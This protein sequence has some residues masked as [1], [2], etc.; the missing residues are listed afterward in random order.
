[1]TKK[2]QLLAAILLGA[3]CLVS[4]AAGNVEA[5]KQ[6]AA[7][8]M[9]CHGPDGNTVPEMFAA[10]KAPKLA[11]QLPEYLEKQLRDFK[12]GRRS[13][14]Q[15]SP[16]AQAVA[17]ADIPDIAA[18][19]ASQPA[20]PNPATKKDQLAVGEKI[21]NKGKN[22][23]EVVAA[24]LGCHG[25]AGAGNTNWSKMMAIQPDILA[26]AIGG[27]HA[28]YIA[29]QLLAYREGKR[30]NDAAH[31]MRDVANRLDAKDIEAV[32]EYVSTLSR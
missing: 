12:T 31:V 15:M 1:M 17:E 2:P 20:R 9:G 22:R 10:L 24:C 11:G 21:F 6:K 32:A 13:N 8:C 14:E 7:A 28:G 16:Q 30:S 29:S 4:H 18:Y 19:F 25:P 27:Q 23:P 5:G 26:P 3:A